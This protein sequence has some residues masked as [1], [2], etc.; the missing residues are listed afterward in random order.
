MKNF[1][2]KLLLFSTVAGIMIGSVIL[3]I[4]KAIARKATFNLKP[5]TKYIILGNS[6]PEAAFNDSLINNFSNIAQSAE[7][8]FYTLIKTKKIFEQNKNIETV[9][10]EFGDNQLPKERNDWIW[11]K[12]FLPHKYNTYSPFMEFQD[13]KLLFKKNTSGFLSNLPLSAGHNF[14]NLLQNDMDYLDDIGGYKYLVRDK[15]DSLLANPKL[16]SESKMSKIELS[17]INIEYLKKLIKYCRESGKKACLIRSPLHPKYEG[18]N[19]ERIFEEILNSN[20]SAIE[21]LDFANF[22]LLNSDFGD[23]EH[24]NY[25]GAK[26][27]S[28]WFNEL[29]NDGLMS[30]PDK[31]QV[32]N[33]KIENYRQGL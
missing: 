28:I 10:I 32:I 22:P 9:F 19:N 15:T 29:V 27:F 8:Y 14:A 3:L 17:D 33:E 12:D 11:G 30:R 1:I 31:Q 4:N 6:R 20:F 16:V 18:F 23:L 5:N 24:L 7:P 26:K 13:H 2:S 25:R 21:F